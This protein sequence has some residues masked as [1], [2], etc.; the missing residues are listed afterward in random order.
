MKALAAFP[1]E[2][3]IR[4]IQV[5]EPG[6]DSPDKVLIHP[7]EVGICGTDRELARFT[8]G[9]PPAESDHLIMGHEC[10][11]EV[12]EV[13]QNVEGIGK[14][15]L[16]VPTVRRPCRDRGCVP[17]Q[18]AQSDMCFTGGFTERGIRGAPG[19]MTELI[20]ESPDFLCRIPAELRSVGVLIEPL[21]IVEKALQELLQV[22]ERLMWKC[23]PVAGRGPYHCRSAL[24]LGAGPIG[25]LA[26]LCLADLGMKTHLVSRN[27]PDDPKIQ[28]LQSA[29]IP[30][31]CS[32]GQTPEDIAAAVDGNIDVVFEA[33]GNSA[34][35]LDYL[36]ILGTNGICVVTGNAGTGN[37]ITINADRVMRRL[38]LLNQLVLGVVNANIGAFHAAARRLPTLG[39]KF[40]GIV[41][42]LITA[43]VPL[44][45]H[46]SYL[47]RKQSGEIKTVLEI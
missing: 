20:V 8:F 4:M 9:E 13:G 25:Y 6:L 36:P 22:Q 21:T 2:K 10:I 41:E 32:R 23:E 15:D 14:G 33:T 34:L 40:P 19:Y 30:Y 45:R 5:S 16:V 43:R 31:F 3:E 44:E 37:Q 1:H 39:E 17:C 29:G 24:V 11:G 42:S 7:L 18:S 47:G 46:A 38:V 28:V 35:W 26:A 27:D 12:V